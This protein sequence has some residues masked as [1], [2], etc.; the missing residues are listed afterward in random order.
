M[1]ANGM[2]QLPDWGK[3][4]TASVIVILFALL[5]SS[6]NPAAVV[7]R[8]DTQALNRVEGNVNLLN[9][10]FAMGLA[11]HPC[12]N[13]VTTSPI[14]KHDTTSIHDTS[15]QYIHKVDTVKYTD[16]V[17]SIRTI[18]NKITI[19]D[20]VTNT[21]VDN[22]LLQNANDSLTAYRLRQAGN[23]GEKLQLSNEVKS[24]KTTL[25]WWKVIAIGLALAW[26]IKLA[27]GIYTSL[28]SAAVK[29][30]SKI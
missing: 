25:T 10:A 23:D 11:L 12:I 17:F 16:T 2:F 15:T 3:I 8:K 20:T 18:T 9:T 1:T 22:R 21:V 26:V 13:T 27:W 6:C 5:L 4:L 30:A 19:H 7:A 24:T 14:V 29:I 28:K